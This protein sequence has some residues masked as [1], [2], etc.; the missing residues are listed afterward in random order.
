[1]ENLELEGVLD[2]VYFYCPKFIDE[3]PIKEI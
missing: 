3:K 1:M 2:V